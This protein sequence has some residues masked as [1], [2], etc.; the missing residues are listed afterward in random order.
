[1]ARKW[2]RPTED[3]KK[4]KCY[5]KNIFEEKPFYVEWN[6]DHNCWGILVVN[7]YWYLLVRSWRQR[8]ERYSD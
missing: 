8:N 5:A 6:S 7:I 4:R 2:R 1:M 3:D